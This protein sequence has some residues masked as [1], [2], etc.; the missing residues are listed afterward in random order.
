MSTGDLESVYHKIILQVEIQAREI[1]AMISSERIRIQHIYRITLF[2][3]LLCHISIFALK[4]TYDELIKTSNATLDS[5]LKPCTGT[6][7]F[8]M[9]IPCSH[10]IREHLKTGQTLQKVDFHEHWWI[11]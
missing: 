2:E 3:P 7:R 4:K 6:L 10:V 11:Q 8:T 1:H 5:P 9:R